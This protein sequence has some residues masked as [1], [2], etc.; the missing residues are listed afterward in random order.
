MSAFRAAYGFAPLGLGEDE[1]TPAALGQSLDAYLAQSGQSARDLLVQHMP[2]QRYV[3]V[4]A[5]VPA[6]APGADDLPPVPPE[7]TVATLAD[8]LWEHTREEHDE[9]H[10]ERAILFACLYDVL[11]RP[12]RFPMLRQLPQ[13]DKRWLLL[14]AD[15]RKVRRLNKAVAAVKSL[16]RGARV[17]VLERYPG[18]IQRAVE[19]GRVRRL[20][21]TVRKFQVCEE[22]QEE[23]EDSITTQ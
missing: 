1:M 5:A 22:E 14:Q 2:L 9:V 11:L 7:A 18:W 16:S 8:V 4:F 6:R 19:E 15:V 10:S 3:D 20:R 17:F 23:E 21:G 13:E 12:D